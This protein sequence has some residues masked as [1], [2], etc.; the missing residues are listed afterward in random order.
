[1]LV[2]FIIVSVDQPHMGVSVISATYFFNSEQCHLNLQPLKVSNK[3]KTN[4]K[5]SITHPPSHNCFS[6]IYSIINNSLKIF[7]Y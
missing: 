7:N 3:I 1:M 4:N 5:L 2:G 6:L